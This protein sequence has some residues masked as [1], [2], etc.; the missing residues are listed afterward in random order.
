MCEPMGLMR[1]R[2]T[3]TH[4][5]LAAA[6]KRFDAV[7]GAAMSADNALLLGFGEHVHHSAVALRPVSFGQAMH[8][9]NVDVIG[10]EFLAKAI[11]V[12]RGP[13]RRHGP[14]SW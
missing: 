1:T 12:G 6:R 4:G 9:A 8:Q 7:A 3:S 10:A 13:R 2:S 5:D 14:R 11:E